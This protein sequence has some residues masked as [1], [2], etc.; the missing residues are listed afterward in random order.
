MEHRNNP[1][2]TRAAVHLVGM[3]PDASGEGNL[4]EVG[5]RS[6]A[7]SDKVSFGFRV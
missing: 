2:K 3:C 1:S 6:F 4:Q 5:G 7:W